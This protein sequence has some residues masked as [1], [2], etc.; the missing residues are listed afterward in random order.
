MLLAAVC[1]PAAAQTDRAA[2]DAAYDA[3]TQT[4]FIP[5]EL[6]TGAPWDGHRDIVATPA[7]LDFGKGGK[8][9][10]SGPFEWTRPS[11]GEHLMVYKRVNGSKEQL[12]TVSSRGDGIGRVYDS[13][14]GRDCI[15]EVKFPLGR[16]HQAESRLFDVPCNGTQHRQIRVTIEDIDYVSNNVPHTLRFH[17]EVLNDSG[18]ATDMHYVYQPGAG[19]VAESGNE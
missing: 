6:W 16:W 15:D 3:S 9:T 10:L 4:R 19:L 14:Y 18:R 17:W 7:H 1:A 13:R 2:W 8:K 5:V 11:N 12:F